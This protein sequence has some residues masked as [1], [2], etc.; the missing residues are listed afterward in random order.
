LR[1]GTPLEW[2]ARRMRVK[3]NKD[4]NQFLKTR[5]RRGWRI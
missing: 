3:N 5:Y 1:A 2:D 4:A